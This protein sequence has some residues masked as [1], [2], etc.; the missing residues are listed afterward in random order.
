MEIALG[1][2]V[3]AI[4]FYGKHHCQEKALAKRYFKRLQEQKRD[5][6]QQD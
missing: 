3:A 4:L 1:I 6:E 2:L 5:G